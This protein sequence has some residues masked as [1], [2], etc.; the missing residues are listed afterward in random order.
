ML[1]EAQNLIQN[2]TGRQ[3]ESKFLRF[4]SGRLI[5]ITAHLIKVNIV[6]AREVFRVERT[7]L[8]SRSY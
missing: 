4:A 2:F 7:V 8:D 5:S 3:T 6:L 1:H